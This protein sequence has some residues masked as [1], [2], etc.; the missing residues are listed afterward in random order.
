M[1]GRGRPSTFN[2]KK[3]ACSGRSSTPCYMKTRISTVLAFVGLSL[4]LAHSAAETPIPASVPTDSAAA[5]AAAPATSAGETD[6]AAAKAIEPP[7]MGLPPLLDQVVRL[8]NSGAD[9]EV[10]R[11]YITKA[12]SPY[13][14]TGNDLVKLRELGV[15]QGVL[16][17][18]IEHSESAAAS[19]TPAAPA[20]AAVTTPAEVQPVAAQPPPSDAAGDFYDALSPYGTWSDVPGYGW[21]WQPTV[22]VVNAGWRP[23]CDNGDWFWSDA[24][25]YWRSYYSWGWGPFHYGR[26]L[27]HGSR[28]WLWCPD[29]AWGPAWVTWRSGLSHCGWAPLPP[30]AC[31]T[32]GIGWTLHGARVGADCGFGLRASHFTFVPTG[33]FLDRHVGHHALRAHD[34]TGVFR[35]TTVV[36]NYAIN[37]Q[38]R[39]VNHGIGRER[40][41]AATHARLEPVAVQDAARTARL[42]GLPAMAQARSIDA[43]ARSSARAFGAANPALRRIELS[44]AA[45]RQNVA[46]VIPAPSQRTLMPN[47]AAAYS[48][49]RSTANVAPGRFAAPRI[50]NAGRASF[51]A[52]RSAPAARSFPTYTRAAPSFVAP[53]SFGGS[54]SFAPSMGPAMRGA[55]MRAGGGMGGRGAIS[56][57]T[58]AGSRR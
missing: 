38:N 3:V 25:W 16:L 26:W 27:S 37:A 15:S 49:V 55:P 13:R 19:E 45:T 48:R 12:A 51:V 21:C 40:I 44:P 31:F 28:G 35:Q 7:K 17:A 8:Q 33:H 18:L 54:R 20:V 39:I 58:T 30:G 50:A 57:V 10:I 36:N 46:R 42:T 4:A 9:E 52:P 11:A 5:P 29:R 56:R 53:R 43:R 47:A 34:A 23:Y 32:A 24:G 14:V 2:E 6:V 1:G 41:A 22:V